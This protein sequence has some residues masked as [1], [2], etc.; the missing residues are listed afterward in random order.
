MVGG[1]SM[2]VKKTSRRPLTS[3]KTKSLSGCSVNSI[4]NLSISMG[5]GVTIRSPIWSV[6]VPLV[7][8]PW[9]AYSP[10]SNYWVMGTSDTGMWIPT[11]KTQMEGFAI[12][13]RASLFAVKVVAEFPLPYT[14]SG[15]SLYVSGWGMAISAH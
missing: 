7:V 9:L 2:P 6:L 12:L 4:S 5:V 15:S 11:D 10:R 14:N 3:L 13:P 1:T 8:H